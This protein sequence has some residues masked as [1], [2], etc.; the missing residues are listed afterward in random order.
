MTF[1]ES[2]TSD[3]EGKKNEKNNIG[4]NLCGRV[5][6]HTRT[7]KKNIDLKRKKK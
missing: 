1:Y 2:A 4:T 7:S 6:K 5:L 3:N